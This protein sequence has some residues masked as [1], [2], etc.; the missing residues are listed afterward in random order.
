MIYINSFIFISME[1]RKHIIYA[2]IDH[3]SKPFYIGRTC[4]LKQRKRNHLYEINQGNTLPKYN[5][6]RKLINQGNDFNKLIISLENDIPAELVDSREIYYIAKFRELGYDLKNL[7]NGGEGAINTIPG[8]SEKLSKIHTGVKRSQQTKD[9]ISEAKRGKLFSKEHKANL[10]I[11]RKKRITTIETRMKLKALKGKINTKQFIL[12]D[13]N[14][15]EYLTTNGLTL[16]CEENGLSAQN[17][18]KVLS[19]ERTHNQGWK[20][21]RKI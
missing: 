4:N 21:K 20:I 8:L 18:Y 9:R 1:E 15:N 6:L 5:K 12:I 10:S 11:A 3:N 7:T 16:F 19:G 14:K 13:P 17:F 2:F